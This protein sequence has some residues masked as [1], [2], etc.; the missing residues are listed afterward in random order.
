MSNHPP[1]AAARGN[2]T[3]VWMSNIT[4]LCD[5]PE[6]EGAI[7]PRY[8]ISD[9]KHFEGVLLYNGVFVSR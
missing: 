1:H 7:M 5:Q 8:V 2:V 9:G 3:V 6:P 4:L